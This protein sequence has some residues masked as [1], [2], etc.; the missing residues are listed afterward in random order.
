MMAAWSAAQYLKFEDERTRAARDLLNAVPLAAPR[1]VV[2]VGCGPGNSTELLVDRYPDA[3]VSGFDRSGRT[4]RPSR[5]SSVTRWTGQ[6][7]V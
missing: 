5:P 2:D 6:I 3:A 1:T 7:G 4:S